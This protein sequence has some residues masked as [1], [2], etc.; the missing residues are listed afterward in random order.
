MFAEAIYRLSARALSTI[1][2]G[3]TAPQWVVFAVAV[4]AFTVL[5]GHRAL[6][7]RFAPKVVA[8]SLAL[9]SPDV[10]MPF[11]LLAPFYALALIGAPQPALQRAWVA[12]LLIALA[13]F[14]VRALPHPWRGII[15]G[16][17]AVALSWGLVAMGRQFV[18]AFRTDA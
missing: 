3:L 1:D 4:S 11:K 15:D 6:A 17:V 8:R 5:E 9:R 14:A 18:V 2:S 16:S 13:V 10:A 12:V 7:L